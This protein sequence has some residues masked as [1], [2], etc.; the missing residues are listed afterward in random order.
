MRAHRT[1][2]IPPHVLALA[3][4]AD[5]WR[6]ISFRR[7][8]AEHPTIGQVTVDWDNVTPSEATVR[9]VLSNLQLRFD[10]GL[11]WRSSPS[12]TG[13]HLRTEQ[14][15]L[16]L[17]PRE[18]FTLRERMGD[19]RVRLVFDAYRFARTGDD[20]YAVGFLFAQ[21]LDEGV[22]L[23]AGPWHTIVRIP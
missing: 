23:Q 8:S 16:P 9:K 18:A 1:Y 11:Q 21:K 6:A 12:R 20:S 7:C 3:E 5:T 19:D 14:F 13:I 17:T 22:P 10:R 4:R 2:S 15:A